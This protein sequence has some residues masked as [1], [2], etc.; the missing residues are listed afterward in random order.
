MRK[1]FRVLDNVTRY[2]QVRHSPIDSVFLQTTWL[3]D[4]PILT[5][6][7]D[8]VESFHYCLWSFS[9]PKHYFRGKMIKYET[10]RM[11]LIFFIILGGLANVLIVGIGCGRPLATEYRCIANITS[12]KQRWYL[13]QDHDGLH[14]YFLRYFITK[15]NKLTMYL[16]DYIILFLC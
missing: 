1:K 7:T 4:V 9:F 12:I 5:H 6:S 13:I 11:I 16:G 2:L 15:S 14:L 8:F 3:C 10:I